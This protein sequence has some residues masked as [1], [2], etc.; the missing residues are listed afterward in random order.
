MTTF[1]NKIPIANSDNFG[2]E[3]KSPHY[4]MGNTYL[5]YS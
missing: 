5:E 4:Y 3:R 1:S 2:T